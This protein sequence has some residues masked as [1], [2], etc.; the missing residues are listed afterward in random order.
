MR[1]NAIPGG[2]NNMNTRE[3]VS[4]VDDNDKVIGKKWRDE[5]LPTDKV[6]VVGIWL[7]NSNHE[8]LIAQRSLNKA[9][10]PGLWGP[11][12]AGTV[13]AG[14]LYEETAVR[15]LEEE[16]GLSISD[17]KISAICKYSYGDSTTGFRFITWYK[18]STD[19]KV[20]EFTLQMEEV[21]DVK[22]VAKDEL[23]SDV[24]SN[25]HK[26]TPGASMWAKTLI[27]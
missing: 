23:L 1:K 24:T 12:A 13:P 6:R 17:V 8:V 20:N 7:E 25:P 14:S 10:Q 26:Y 22:W 19:K 11:S 9:V 5:L 15:E 18:G 4:I 27:N 3:E 16:L 2:A 21:S